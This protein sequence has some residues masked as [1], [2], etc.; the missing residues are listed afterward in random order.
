LRKIG[1]INAAARALFARA[2]F[3][4]SDKPRRAALL[5]DVK[6]ILPIFFVPRCRGTSSTGK[7][8]TENIF[9]S[10][11]RWFIPMEIYL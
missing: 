1:L 6:T 3:F 11:F 5:F 10:A 7:R 4:S 9:F 8:M 2:A